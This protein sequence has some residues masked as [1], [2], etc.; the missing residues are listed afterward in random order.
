MIADAYGGDEA[1]EKNAR[2]GCSGCPLTDKDTALDSLLKMAYWTYLAPIKRLRP[3]WRKLREAQNR[4]RKTGKDST[5][6]NKQRMG[7]LTMQARQMAFNEVMAIQNEIN[8]VA[9][10]E[11]KPKVILLNEEEQAFI[12]QCW[13]DNPWP[14][15]WDGTEPTGDILMDTVYSDGSIQPIFNFGE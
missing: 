7:P 13:A 6:K 1:E 15:K 9:E 2:T 5:D 11:A 3:L 12:Q 14:N 10:R 4:L 8:E